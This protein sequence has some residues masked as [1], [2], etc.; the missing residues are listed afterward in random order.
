MEVG[1][2]EE[3]D[4]DAGSVILKTMVEVMIARESG[5]GGEQTKR[6]NAA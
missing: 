3:D 5:K 2:D 4:K 1:V 6:R